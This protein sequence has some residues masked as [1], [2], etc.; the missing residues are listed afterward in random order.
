MVRRGEAPPGAAQRRAHNAPRQLRQAPC[1]CPRP[2]CLIRTPPPQAL[3]K[4]RASLRLAHPQRRRHLAAARLA[5]CAAVSALATSAQARVHRGYQRGLRWTQHA[6]L[7]PVPNTSATPLLL[8]RCSDTGLWRWDDRVWRV[9]GGCGCRR[10]THLGMAATRPAAHPGG[11]LPASQ[12]AS[13]PPRPLHALSPA[14]LQPA[15]GAASAPAFGGGGA[16]AFGARPGGFGGFTASPAPFG[17]S[18][19]RGD[20]AGQAHVT[21]ACT[22]CSGQHSLHAGSDGLPARSLPSTARLWRGQRTRVWRSQ[23]AGV[24]GGWLWRQHACVWRGQHARLWR[25]QHA[26]VWRQRTR[27]WRR[28]LAVWRERARVWRA[29][30][31]PRV[32]RLWRGKHPGVWRPRQHT[33]VWQRRR[34]WRRLWGELPGLGVMQGAARGA[35]R[36]QRCGRTVAPQRASGSSAI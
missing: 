33:R 24:R 35:H 5:R 23:H 13:R 4:G 17:A 29:R 25:G 36:A 34:V 14:N 18:T 31:H 21:A 16:A 20:A 12:P 10:A 28:S 3:D 1:G 22:A 2:S 26:C 8:A 7:P 11:C 27:V 19:V 6:G 30:Q 32:W 15:F 9:A